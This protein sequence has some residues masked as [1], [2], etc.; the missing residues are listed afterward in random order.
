MQTTPNALVLLCVLFCS[1]CGP[2]HVAAARERSVK[3]PL[4]DYLN[5]QNYP[6]AKRDQFCAAY[7]VWHALHHCG[8][9]VS[10]DGVVGRLKLDGKHGASV[11]AVVRALNSYGIFAEAGKIDLENAASLRTPFI[12]RAI[13]S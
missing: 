5:E 7:A 1:I 10:L 13:A 3:Q 4:P 9:D 12:P 11:E 6:R 2:E 8:L